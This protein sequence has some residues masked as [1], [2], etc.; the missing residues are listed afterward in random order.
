M[1]TTLAWFPADAPDGASVTV[2]ETYA[3]ADFTSLGSFGSVDAFGETLVSQM[4]RSRNGPAAP[5]ARLVSARKATRE[6]ADLY[7]IDYD[8]KRV[9][10]PDFRHCYSAVALAFDGRHNKLFTVTGQVAAESAAEWGDAVRGAVA[11][12][13]PPAS[14]F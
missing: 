6:G 11:S 10:E 13:V 1:T 4:D 7:L 12:F 9:N 5:A 8:V 2:V 3:S 14:R